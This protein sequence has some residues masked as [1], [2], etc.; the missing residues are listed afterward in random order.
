MWRGTWRSW[1]WRQGREQSGDQLQTVGVVQANQAPR[2]PLL[3]VLFKVGKKDIVREVLHV[4]CIV[5]HDIELPWKKLQIVAVSVLPLVLAGVD[6]EV[7]GC[8]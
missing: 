2:Q 4:G 3:V 5:G 7:G 6:T 8:G 1:P